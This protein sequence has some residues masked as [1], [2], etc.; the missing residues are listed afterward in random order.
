MHRDA[1]RLHLAA[2]HRRTTLVDLQRHQSGGEFDHVSS[3]TQSQQCI[4][5]LEPEQATA[6]H[7]ADVPTAGVGLHGLEIG[8]GAVHEGSGQVV[9]GDR[10]YEGRGAGGENHCIVG[11]L[12]TRG[13]GDHSTDTVDGHCS[14]AQA[15]IQQGIVVVEPLRHQ[16]QV[17]LGTP[18]EPRRERHPVVGRSWF[19]GQDGHLPVAGGVPGPQRFHQSLSHHAIADQ[20][21][22]GDPR[23]DGMRCPDRLPMLVVSVRPLACVRFHVG[24]VVLTRLDPVGADRTVTGADG[25]TRGS[26]SRSCDVLSRNPVPAGGLM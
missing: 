1:Q 25:T 17:G 21:E 2:Q 16:G 3:K 19:L 13:S 20:D 18:G 8:D 4:G 15:Q 24:K 14:L 23:L 10:R 9:P 6:D 26:S 22:M 5:R 12:L 11:D 7:R